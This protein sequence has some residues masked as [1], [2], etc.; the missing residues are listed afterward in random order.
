[1]IHY[2]L[3]YTFEKFCLLLAIHYVE[4]VIV[5]VEII[6]HLLTSLHF[7]LSQSTTYKVRCLD[8]VVRQS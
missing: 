7:F 3:L 2:S 6:H 8:S 1:M 4:A 5:K